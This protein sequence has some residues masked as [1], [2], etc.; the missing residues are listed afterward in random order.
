MLFLILGQCKEDEFEC[1]NHEC[2]PLSGRCDSISQCTDGSDEFRCGRYLPRKL[3]E[4]DLLV[5][6][7]DF[8]S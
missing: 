5:F 1:Q 6:K 4:N 3:T 8:I 2:V 7:V